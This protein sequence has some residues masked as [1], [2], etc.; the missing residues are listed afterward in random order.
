[1]QQYHTVSYSI[2]TVVYCSSF[3]IVL[4]LLGNNKKTVFRFSDFLWGQD[5]ALPRF[6]AFSIANRDSG[7]FCFC[8]CLFVS[9]FVCWF[10]CLFVR[11]FVCSFVRLFV[12]SFVRL[13]VC[14]FACFFSASI[15][16]LFLFLCSFFN[17]SRLCFCFLFVCSFVSQCFDIMLRSFKFLE[18]VTSRVVASGKCKGQMENDVQH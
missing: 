1:M 17:V 9:S 8:V 2:I 3:S 16:C 4:K 6:L 10:V 18:V 5:L 14:L 13:F 15:F 12:C 7:C 11:L